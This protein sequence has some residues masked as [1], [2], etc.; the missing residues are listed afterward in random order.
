MK[1]AWILKNKMQRDQKYRRSVGQ[2]KKK[3]LGGSEYRCSS[4]P[5]CG[6]D[7]LQCMVRLTL[8]SGGI[9]FVQPY[10]SGGKTG[11]RRAKGRTE[12]FKELLELL[13]GFY[14]QA[15]HWKTVFLQAEGQLAMLGEDGKDMIMP[16]TR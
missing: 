15:C 11:E 8:V 7:L 1:G 16:Y 6:V 3:A 4:D 5:A 10:L 9:S 14:R 13:S 2:V 12:L